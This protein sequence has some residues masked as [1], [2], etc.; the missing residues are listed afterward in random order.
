[1]GRRGLWGGILWGCKKLWGGNVIYTGEAAGG[2]GT[3]LGSVRL[4]SQATQRHSLTSHTA[5][6]R[7]SASAFARPTLLRT[8]PYRMGHGRPYPAKRTLTSLPCHP[9]PH[10]TP[11]HHYHAPGC[12]PDT[13]PRPGHQCHTPLTGLHAYVPL[14]WANASI[15]GVILSPV[16][17]RHLEYHVYGSRILH[18]WRDHSVVATNSVNLWQQKCKGVYSFR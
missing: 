17:Y 11:S 5:Y 6:A 14:P 8:I 15:P 1:V 18:F 2:L 4:C 3:G 13:H 16:M 12:V 9:R 7:L 10:H